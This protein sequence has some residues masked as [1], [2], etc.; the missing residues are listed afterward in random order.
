M[1]FDSKSLIGRKCKN[2]RHYFPNSSVLRNNKLNLRMLFRNWRI[3][4]KVCFC[5]SLSLKL[6]KVINYRINTL[7]SFNQLILLMRWSHRKWVCR[8]CWWSN[9]SW[10]FAKRRCNVAMP[11]KLSLFDNFSHAEQIYGALLG[12]LSMFNAKKGMKY[13]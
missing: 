11:L 1:W 10:S 2:I 4:V 9:I 7:W 3:K 13:I 8:R 12:G 6:I 5:L